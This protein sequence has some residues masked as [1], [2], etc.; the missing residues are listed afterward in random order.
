MS[1][2]KQITKQITSLDSDMFTSV[3]ESE[4]VS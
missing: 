4:L 3:E 2:K 1:I